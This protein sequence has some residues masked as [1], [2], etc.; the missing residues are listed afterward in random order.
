MK[1]TILMSGSAVILLAI[2]GGVYV[3][4][5]SPWRQGREWRILHSE[6]ISLYE[7]GHYDQ[8]E[9]LFKRSLVIREK[10][11]GSEHPLVAESL[12]TI[13]LLY[14]K[15]DRDKEAEELEKR[16]AAIREIRK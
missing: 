7:H 4:I 5:I 3:L 16:A 14:K 10:A 6:F 11:L 2:C 9:S 15:T 13:A 8:A 12:R 1:R